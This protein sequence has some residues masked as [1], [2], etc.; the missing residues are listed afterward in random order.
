MGYIEVIY[1]IPVCQYVVPYAN[2]LAASNIFIDFYH[3]GESLWR[4]MKATKLQ[5]L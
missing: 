4:I 5:M 1:I 2:I 3:I